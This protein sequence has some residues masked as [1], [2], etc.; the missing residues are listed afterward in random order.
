M[1]AGLAVLSILCGWL[2]VQYTR[3]ILEVRSIRRQLEE[4]ER[5]SRMELGVYSRQREMLALCRKLNELGRQNMQGQIRYEKA[6]KQLKQNITALAHDIRTPLAGA[7]GYVQLAGECRERGRQAYY[8]QAAEG[9]LKELGDMLEE[10]FLFTKL[11]DADFEPDMRR[12]QV[13]PLLGDC[14]VGMYLQFEEKGMTPKVRFDSE[15]LW[16]EADEECLRR[17][18]HNLIRNALLHGTGNLMITQRETCIAFENAV[19]ETSRPDTEQIFEQF[20]KAYS[21]RRKGSSG[22]GL[23]IVK[24]LMEK[25]GGSVK[26]ELE[27]ETLRIVLEFRRQAAKS[28]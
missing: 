8:L 11:S 21:A 24:E 19:S 12:L 7:S 20:Y 14:L 16:V 13:L 25:M 26:A 3:S 9:R 27:K 23:F 1:T 2:L 10:L 17:I 5:G 15:E 22:L 6:Q 4:I 18:F 28:F